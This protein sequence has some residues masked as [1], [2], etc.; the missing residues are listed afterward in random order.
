VNAF[1]RLHPALQHHIV[2]SLGW[3]DLRP[4]QSLS[5]D[6]CLS[7]AN[8]VVLAPTAGG[9]TEAA[10]F[11]VISQMLTEAWDGLSVLYVSPIRALLNNQEQRLQRYFELV[12]R[13]TV[14]WHG[15]T[16]QGNKRRVITDSPDCLLT[17][18]E[19]LEA[20]LV[21]AKIDH[22]EFFKN[23]QVVVIDELHAFAGDDRGWHLLSVLSRIQRLAGRDL[24][25]IGL[26]ATVGNPDEM[27]AWLSSGSER[28]RQVVCPPSTTTQAPDVQLDYVG[29]LDNAAK[30]IS[31]LHQGEKRLVFC[32]SR[33]RV[34]QLTL[35]L[36]ERQVETFVSHSSLGVE[37]R[38]AAEHAFAQKQNCVIVATSS[39]ELGL[40]VGDL[41]RVIQIDAPSTV[42]SFLQRMGRTG[43]R[44][45]AKSNCL[46]LTTS[47]D[48]LLRAAA[49]LNLWQSGYVEPVHAPPKPFHILAQQ[50]LALVLQERGIGQRAWFEWVS[51]VPAFAHMPAARIEEVVQHLL[52]SGI[53]WSDNGIL[54]FAPEGEAEYG[55][56][57]FLELLSVF[58]SPPLFRV[59]SGQ[60]EL[61]HVHESTFFKRQVG[62]VILVLAGRSWKTNYL[63][64]KRRIAHVEPT[65]ERGR[66]RW[67]GEGQFLSFRIC[68][69]I[70][71]ILATDSTD[72]SWS[73]RATAQM[74]EVRMEC[75][76]ASL[77]STSVVQHPSGEVHW[78]TFGGGVANTLISQHLVPGQN[79]KAD[80]LCIP[81][82]TSMKL[83]DVESLVGSRLTEEIRPT[84]DEAAIENLKFSE[85]LP[86]QVAAEVFVARFN[87]P[88][89][90]ATICKEPRRVVIES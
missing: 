14:C 46:F 28:K 48:G 71:R 31:L 68:Q 15:D 32:D 81:F 86:H 33:S 88:E 26:S 67:L 25:R 9:K 59:L 8:V 84:P 50:L 30:V 22:L 53:L 10:F 54:S 74:E 38:R 85:C 56:K 89:A 57:N 41:D 7:G 55:R 2:N 70:R 43:R 6:A 62:P 36:R 20:I 37:E 61:G 3:A 11:P 75:P 73:Q 35:F 47:D 52:V 72:P 90:L 39:L 83:S 21:S 5:I 82:P 58:T 49:L 34:E 1:D 69:A 23:V 24:Q 17:T 12:G 63:D 27:L 19:S 51:D 60:K 40:D 80:N 16:S 65:D 45:G 66:S 76:W 79:A 78:W 29:T 77:D 64:W 87:E 42:S 18:P 44:T 13:R 4:V